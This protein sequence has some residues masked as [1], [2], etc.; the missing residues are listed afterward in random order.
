MLR[1]S[2]RTGGWWLV[3]CLVRAALNAAQ[4]PAAADTTRARS[5][6]AYLELLRSDIR[7][8][9]VALISGMMPEEDDAKS[10]PVDR[11]TSRSSRAST[12]SG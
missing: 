9:K 6:Q 12:T 5:L 10:W 3:A 11:G 2:R 7:D 1:F 8:Q 4:A